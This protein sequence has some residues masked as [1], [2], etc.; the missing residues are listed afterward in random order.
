MPEVLP[1]A[2]CKKILESNGKKY[3]DQQ[4]EKIRDTLYILGELD[5]LIFKEMSN[6]EF[7]SPEE[8][9]AA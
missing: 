1:L 9:K 8:N 2:H 6:T 7:N 4:V 5:Y 3:S